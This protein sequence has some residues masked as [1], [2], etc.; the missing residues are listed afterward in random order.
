MIAAAE[1]V[2]VGNRI[3]P[4]GVDPEYRALYAEILEAMAE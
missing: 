3:D 1:L 4:W 2:F